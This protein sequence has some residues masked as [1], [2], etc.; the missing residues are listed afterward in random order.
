M[1]LSSYWTAWRTAELFP[2]HFLRMA[3]TASSTWMRLDR[4]SL[5]QQ[6]PNA[7]QMSHFPIPVLLQPFPVQ[8]R[9]IDMQ[10]VTSRRLWV[11]LH[12]WRKWTCS[13]K[14]LMIL[15]GTCLCYI[16]IMSHLQC[17]TFATFILLFPRTLP[18]SPMTSL[19]QFSTWL[20][21]L[22]PYQSQI[23]LYKC[24]DP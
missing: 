20:P 9:L 7:L 10:P 23:I 17:R 12:W 1:T 4:W 24:Q 19:Y 13:K 11:E 14:R 15:R 6:I 3:N 21:C 16:I 18:L 22:I 2:G 5:Y 8:H